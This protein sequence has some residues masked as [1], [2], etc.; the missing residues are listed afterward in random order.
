MNGVELT[1]NA[2]ENISTSFSLA[3]LK[4]LAEME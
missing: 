2:K 1:H 4:V 3:A